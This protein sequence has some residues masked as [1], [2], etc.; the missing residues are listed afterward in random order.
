MKIQ[1]KKMKKKNGMQCRHPSTQLVPH[2]TRKPFDKNENT[3]TKKIT[4]ENT[5]NI[6]KDIMNIIDY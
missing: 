1:Y 2:S 5:N 6:F 4:N 3:N